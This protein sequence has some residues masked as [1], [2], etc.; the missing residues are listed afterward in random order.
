[1]KRRVLRDIKPENLLLDKTGRVKIADFGIAKMLGPVSGPN[2]GE[3]SA[4]DLATQAAVGTPNYSAPEQKTDPGRVDSRADIYSLGV[5]FYEM[6]TGELPGKK[7]E[8]PSKKVAMDVRLDEVVL[9]ALEKTP[10]LRWQ[11]AADMRSKVETFLAIPPGSS[12][13]GSAQ[14]EKP[15]ARRRFARPV[16]LAVALLA[17]IIGAIALFQVIHRTRPPVQ[18][19]SQ[20][21]FLQK[22]MSNEIARATLIGSGQ[23]AIQLFQTSGTY[24]QA[25]Q[26]GIVKEVPFQVQNAL[27]TEETVGRL[28]RSPKIQINVPNAV[29]RNL[30]WSIAP[31]LFLGTGMFLL[32]L[33]ILGMILYAVW[34]A[35]R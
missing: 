25:G 23:P 11:T 35:R 22:F 12:P 19:L 13:R 20:R 15:K 16:M 4:S 1:M 29:P 8:P 33:L 18:L 10:E 6:L 31:F 30:V 32:I 34:R 7:I 21:E 24:N 3:S 9:R 14:T 17:I 5:V 27:L 26:D 2:A 28:L